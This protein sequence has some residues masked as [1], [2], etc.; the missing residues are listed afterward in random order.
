[1]C[2][3]V[4][5]DL[6][7]IETAFPSRALPLVIAV[8]GL[9]E[10]GVG[11]NV[12]LPEDH[13]LQRLFL[14]ANWAHLIAPHHFSSFGFDGHH[15]PA[16]AY[17]SA[18]EQQEIVNTVVELF[19]EE[20]HID[21]RVIGALEWSL[22]EVTDNVLTHAGGTGGLIQVTRYENE[23][24]IV[25]CD[26]GRGIGD[27]M[28]EVFSELTT[29]LSAVQRAMLPGVTSG[30]GQ[31]NGLAGIE[32]IA[33]LA[34]GELTVVSG[35]AFGDIRFN[36]SDRWTWQ[37]V[38]GGVRFPG[39]AVTLNLPLDVSVDLREALSFQGADWEI[40][41]FIDARYEAV[42]GEFR[43]VMKDERRGTGSRDAGRALRT[44][45]ENLLAADAEN[46]VTIDFSEVRMISSSFADEYLGKLRLSLGEADFTR[47][48]RIVGLET[49]VRPVLAGAVSQ[50]L[51][52]SL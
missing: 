36:K 41:D 8:Q 22:N 43:I 11:V 47:R 2:D 14:N 34:K 32:N 17:A 19:L 5:F 39:T 29:D 40:F 37:P 38:I 3:E 9:Q 24:H 13:S 6:S 28:R 25:V 21:R 7:A 23:A 44:K 16:T 31:G 15:V 52:S 18:R 42:E 33:H 4:T 49:S 12:T 46:S 35:C 10:R 1:L 26:G 27:S 20:T 30:A 51:R 48:V 45:T 50:R